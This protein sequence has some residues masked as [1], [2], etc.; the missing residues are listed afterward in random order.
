MLPK[1]FGSDAVEIPGA[2]QLLDS[3]EEAKA[4]WAIVTSGTPALVEGW[5]EVMQLA[6]P[7]NLVTADD[8]DNGKPGES[9]DSK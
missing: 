8:V 9:I 6:R 5:L 3:L 2:R 1:K 7:K 4:P